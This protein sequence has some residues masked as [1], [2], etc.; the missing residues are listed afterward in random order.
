MV[1][2]GIVC[3]VNMLEVVTMQTNDDVQY[4]YSVFAHVCVCVADNS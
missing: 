4:V 3:T 1:A 2:Y